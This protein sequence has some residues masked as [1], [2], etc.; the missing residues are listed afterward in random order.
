MY[1]KD[2]NKGIY[3]EKKVRTVAFSMDYEHSH[4]YYEIYCLIKGNV[5]YFVNNMVYQLTAGDIFIVLP[6]EKHYTHYDGNSGCERINVYCSRSTVSSG[7]LGENGCFLN[8]LKRSCKVVIPKRT[9]VDISKLLGQ[10]IRENNHPDSLSDAFLMLRL[11][12]LLLQI[13]R[14]GQFV[15]S[16]VS[17][18]KNRS[19]DNV[20]KY[21]ETNYNQPI[22]LEDA[23][24]I[25]E[26]TPAYFSRKF[27]K[28]M[29]I[30][31]KDY[32]NYIRNR[33]ACQMLLTTDDTVTKIANDCGF[34]SSNYFKDIFRKM[35]GVSPR[36]FRK[37]MQ[38]Y[39]ENEME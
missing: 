5:L 35:N 9:Q 23:A 17:V 19:I 27:K 38:G 10:M 39:G 28:E 16:S 30:T 34:N 1:N 3:A 24:E 29:G 32:L 13:E 8:N 33:H 25:G 12:E 15:S 7:I 14:N 18:E 22:T 37:R 26:L 6:N 31:F 20:L 36:E 11:T 21:I 2:H 4:P